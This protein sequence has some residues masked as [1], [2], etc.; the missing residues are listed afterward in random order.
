M[1]RYW[2]IDVSLSS[3]W[4]AL[5][6]SSKEEAIKKAKE[7]LIKSIDEMTINCLYEVDSNGNEIG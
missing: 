7:D 4:G 3:A 6:A 2:S 1:K 5:E